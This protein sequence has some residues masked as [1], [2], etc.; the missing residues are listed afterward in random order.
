MRLFAV[1]RGCVRFD[2]AWCSFK[3]R[4]ERLCLTLTVANLTLMRTRNSKINEYKVRNK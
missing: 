1:L 2:L 3:N 4:N